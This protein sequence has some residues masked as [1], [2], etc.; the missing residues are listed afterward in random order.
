MLTHTCC[1]FAIHRLL[2]VQAFHLHV[3]ARCESYVPRM[4]SAL[5]TTVPWWMDRRGG[6]TIVLRGA[7]SFSEIVND[8][9]HNTSTLSLLLSHVIHLHG[10][11]HGLNLTAALALFIDQTSHYRVVALPHFRLYF[12][13]INL[14]CAADVLLQPLVDRRLLMPRALPVLLE[15]LL[16]QV[17]DDVV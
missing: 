10:L 8:Q 2:V 12:V 5:L 7:S 11:F 4:V 13:C 3:C 15:E 17:L 1:R 16:K 9:Q 6:W 14:S